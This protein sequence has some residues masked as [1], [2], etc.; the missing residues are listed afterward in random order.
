MIYDVDF[1]KYNAETLVKDLEIGL[2]R[3]NHHFQND[4][5]K[6][7]QFGRILPLNTT[8][9]YQYYNIFGLTSGSLLFHNL[10]KQVRMAVRD[11]LNTEEPLWFQS[12]VNVQGPDELLDWHDH[13]DCNCHGFFFL[14]VEPGTTRTIF[15]DFEVP[16]EIGKL[17]I[18]KPY[19]KHK[20]EL[21]K[22]FKGKR[23]SIAFDVSNHEDMNRMVT[24][25]GDN[26]NLS[27]F[28]LD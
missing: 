22:P 14:Q 17:Y 2:N 16:N 19:T 3:W 18:G 8:A 20:V 25:Y 27:Y 5:L 6:V 15:E 10:L 11:F 7:N 21:V 23:I 24:T 12:W 9:T 26:L 1:I 13:K 28:P 4:E